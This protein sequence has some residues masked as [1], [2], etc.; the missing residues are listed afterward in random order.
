MTPFK[1]ASDSITHAY[2]LTF[3][4]SSVL[5]PLPP[6][7]DEVPL[8]DTMLSV[9]HDAPHITNMDVT[10]DVVYSS[11]SPDETLPSTITRDM[12]DV[13]DSGSESPPHEYQFNHMNDAPCIPDMQEINPEYKTIPISICT[14]R[15]IARGTFGVVYA[16]THPNIVAKV[17]TADDPA[18]FIF[19]GN[20]DTR[21]RA[22]QSTQEHYMEQ[23]VEVMDVCRINEHALTIPYFRMAVIRDPTVVIKGCNIEYHNSPES[24]FFGNI[25]V[26]FMEYI[27]G[28]LG[29][30]MTFCNKRENKS[31]ICSYLHRLMHACCEKGIYIPDFKSD[32]LI[33][34][35]STGKTTVIDLDGIRIK[36]YHY[37]NNIT[38]M[39]ATVRGSVAITKAPGRYSM[40]VQTIYAISAVID[41]FR[42]EGDVDDWSTYALAWYHGVEAEYIV[43]H[44]LGLWMNIPQC[45]E[46]I[47]E[48]K[49]VFHTCIYMCP[50]D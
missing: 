36:W 41:F 21:S 15:E 38:P 35:Q 18:D 1:N 2:D 49:V 14:D 11:I 4:Y 25:V 30:E 46:S 23:I 20:I 26:M 37:P 31:Y 39:R 27:E 17:F 28:V 10:M 48:I 16:T 13:T 32:N 44:D 33:I 24:P 47:P 34:D 7:H 50:L 8:R 3:T 40:C 12:I 5:I 42:Q 22:N 43:D 9:P 29:L 45:L 19:P 6:S